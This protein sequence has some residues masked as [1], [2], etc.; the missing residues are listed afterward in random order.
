MDIIQ[1][2]AFLVC[3]SVLMLAPAPSIAA[4]AGSG[5]PPASNRPLI[6]L[7]PASQ[8]SSPST[9]VN[10]MP[11]PP[12]IENI[13]VFVTDQNS[14]SQEFPASP[15]DSTLYQGNAGIS[16]LSVSNDSPPAPPFSMDSPVSVLNVQNAAEQKPSAPPP[17]EAGFEYPWKTL[18]PFEISYIVGYQE[19]YDADEQIMFYVQGNSFRTETEPQNGFNVQANIDDPA[20]QRSVSGS[21]GE[22]DEGRR[23]WLI[24]LKAPRENTKSYKLSISL[25]C[26]SDVSP[27]AEIYGRAAQ[28]SKTYPLQVR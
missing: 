8:I 1:T 12:P 6:S 7:P 25:Y 22:Y 11:P 23:A 4:S 14:L 9:P 17:P 5:E 27:C 10:Q 20:E 26:A 24:K 13:Q 28:I 18:P 3:V 16:R 15:T 21:Y 2:K 19:V